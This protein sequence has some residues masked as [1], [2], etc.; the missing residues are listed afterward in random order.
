[1]PVTLFPVGSSVT[2]VLFLPRRSKFISLER[3][4]FATMGVGLKLSFNPLWLTTSSHMSFPPSILKSLNS[5]KSSVILP[6]STSMKRHTP[7]PRTRYIPSLLV[8]RSLNHFRNMFPSV[9]FVSSPAGGTVRL[10]L[11]FVI[12]NP[13]RR[14]LTRRIS[15]APRYPERGQLGGVLEWGR[16]HFIYTH[17]LLREK[18]KE[19]QKEKK[20]VTKKEKKD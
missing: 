18:E 13:H 14:G 5:S 2:S 1:M 11:T 8:E 4:I 7:F 19:K 20:K 6:P 16:P 3:G 15:G 10:L 9:C 12:I 17:F